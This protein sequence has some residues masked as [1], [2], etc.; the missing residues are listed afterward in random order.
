MKSN[1]YDFIGAQRKGFTY[2]HPDVH[3]KHTTENCNIKM[4]IFSE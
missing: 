1:K 4:V 3:V 2:C